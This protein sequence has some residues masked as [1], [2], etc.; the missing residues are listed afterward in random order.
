[1]KRLTVAF[2]AL[3]FLASCGAGGAPSKPTKSL[4]ERLAERSAAA[5]AETE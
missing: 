2:F 5:S 4:K 3:A 1:M